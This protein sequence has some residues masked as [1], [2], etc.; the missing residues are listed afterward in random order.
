MAVKKTSTTKKT[1]GRKKA[2]KSSAVVQYGNIEFSE[3][4]CLKKAQS[5]AS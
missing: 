5:L 1:A 2:V 3:E 4:A